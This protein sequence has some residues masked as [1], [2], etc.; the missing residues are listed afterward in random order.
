MAPRWHATAPTRMRWASRASPGRPPASCWQSAAMIRRAAA[1]AGAAAPPVATTSRLSRAGT[2]EVR[3]LH[4]ASWLPVASLAHPQRLAEGPDALV[5]YREVAA[6]GPAAGPAAG[7]A[8]PSA[9][10]AV[11]VSARAG[12]QAGRGADATVVPHELLLQQSPTQ[13]VVCELPHSLPTVR[14]AADK[15]NP[16]MGIGA[17]LRSC[18]SPCCTT[19]G[20][21]RC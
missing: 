19:A 1:K 18:R 11:H 2:Q 15:A 16:R 8:K 7:P 17:H 21:P 12:R 10:A 3:I 5:V 4:H 9:G 13:Y 14:P 6:P 20:L